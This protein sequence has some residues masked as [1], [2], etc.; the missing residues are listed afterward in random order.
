MFKASEIEFKSKSL[1][2]ESVQSDKQKL[3]QSYK[4][5]A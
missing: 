2:F 1:I 4:L 5:A 3:S